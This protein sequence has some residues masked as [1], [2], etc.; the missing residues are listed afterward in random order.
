MLGVEKLV[1]SK[2]LVKGSNR[3]IATADE[4]VGLVRRSELC[5]GNFFFLIFFFFSFFFFCPGHCRSFG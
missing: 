1:H 3:R 5:T 2:L 4:H